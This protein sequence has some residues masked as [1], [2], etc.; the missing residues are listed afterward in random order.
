MRFH[1]LSRAQAAQAIAQMARS[2]QKSYVVKPYSE[3]MP[4]AARDPRLRD[5]LNGA[6]LCLPDGV[7]ILWAAHYLSLPG[8]SLRALAQLPLSLAALVFNP[9]AVRSPLRQHMA[10]VDLTWEMLARLDEARAR[11]F[12]LGGTEQEVSATRHRI[13]ARLRGLDVVGAR[14]GYFRPTGEE[15]DR[16]VEAI[17]AAAPQVLLVAMGFPRQEEWIAANLPLLAVNVAVAEGGSFSFISG[18][19]RRAPLWMRRSGLEW[20]FRLLRQPWRLRRQLAILHFVW[21]VVRERLRLARR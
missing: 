4:R 15:N 20:L 6:D 3:F 10:G 19:T 18:A 9:G 14:H 2:G 13:E 21:L 16:I 12:L 5:I 11:V 1:S 8:G 7:G 17:G